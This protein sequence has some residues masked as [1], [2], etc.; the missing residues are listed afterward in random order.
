MLLHVSSSIPVG[1]HSTVQY[2]PSYST[3]THLLDVQSDPIAEGILKFITTYM[4]LAS[5]HLPADVLPTLSH[6]SKLF[7][8]QC[9]DF[10]AMYYG[11]AACITALDRFK[12]RKSRPEASPVCW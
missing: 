12:L 4:F 7:Q 10:A 3:T 8:K 2:R 1:C 11:V 6:L 9:V 5:T